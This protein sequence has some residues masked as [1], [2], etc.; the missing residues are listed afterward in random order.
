MVSVE[1]FEPKSKSIHFGVSAGEPSLGLSGGM[2]DTLSPADCE[3]VSEPML[4]DVASSV[5]WESPSTTMIFSDSENLPWP[6]F[7]W[8]FHKPDLDL[9]DFPHVSQGYSLNV[10]PPV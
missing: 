3:W 10:K 2:G 5:V 9:Y 4:N 6:N 8:C 1:S 7:F